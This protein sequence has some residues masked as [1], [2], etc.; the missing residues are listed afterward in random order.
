MWVV[1]SM[2]GWQACDTRSVVFAYERAI[3]KHIAVVFFCVA[4][5]HQCET[6][7]EGAVVEERWSSSQNGVGISIDF[8]VHPIGAAIHLQGVATSHDPH[9]LGIV[10]ATIQQ[11]TLCLSFAVG[12]EGDVFQN[13]VVAVV[14]TRCCS[15]RRE[16]AFQ[17]VGLDVGWVGVE[18]LVVGI[19][20]EHSIS[21]LTH[22][23]DIAF[24]SCIDDF[25]VFSI[26]HEDG[27][28][29][30]FALRKVGHV[31]QCSLQG[32]EISRSISRDG[33]ELVGVDVKR[34]E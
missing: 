28:S 10:L 32:A 25:F 24:V 18:H 5:P 27:P 6:A 29:F 22:N 19:V 33:D 23:R 11:Q 2:I 31:I 14:Q 21:A 8:A 15:P 34:G 9:V 7:F 30:G 26:L 4:N 1:L 3:H 17:F 16:G 13:Q 20:Y 12:L